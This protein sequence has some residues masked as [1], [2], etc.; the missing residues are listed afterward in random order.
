LKLKI[1]FP[2]ILIST[3]L[4]FVFFIIFKQSWMTQLSYEKQRLEKELSNLKQNKDELDQELYSLQ[5]PDN[6]KEYAS[7]KLKMSKIKIGQVKKL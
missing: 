5:D 4:V 7:K 6:V 3:N 2:L 1:G